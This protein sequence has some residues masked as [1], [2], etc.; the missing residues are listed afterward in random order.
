MKLIIAGSRSLSV[1]PE[2]ISKYVNE[3][4]CEMK[5]EHLFEQDISV[6][7][8]VSGTA[9][10]IDLSGEEW[11]KEQ[12]IPITRFPAKWE[13]FGKSAGYKRNTEMAEYADALLAIYDGTSKGTKHMIN[14]AEKKDLKVVVKYHIY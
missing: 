9:R 11:A 12:N 10:G 8:V 14:L 3:L 1:S 4:L 6:T 7:E 5:K 13:L 2:T